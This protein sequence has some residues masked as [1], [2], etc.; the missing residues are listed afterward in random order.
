MLLYNCISHLLSSFWWQSSKWA[1][2]GWFGRYVEWW[3]LERAAGQ[4][5]A[6][7]EAPT[8]VAKFSLPQ[9]SFSPSCWSCL[10]AVLLPSE[11]WLSP[12]FCE[13]L[14]FI[15]WPLEEGEWENVV[16]VTC[17]GTSFHHA[18]L[19]AAVRWQRL[20]TCLPTQ[21]I[22][23]YSQ[24]TEIIPVRWLHFKL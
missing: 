22:V 20:K 23:L 1:E 12:S 7:S 6:E 17:L 15:H 24:A 21:G 14:V 8:D 9:R 2:W 11:M 16:S 18:C 10:Y 4:N 13:S 3:W 19:L 5:R